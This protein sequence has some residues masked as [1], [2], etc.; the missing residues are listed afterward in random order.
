MEGKELDMDNHEILKTDNVLVRIMEL[1]KDGSTEWHHHTE[2]A[3][4]FVCLKGAVRVETRD[5]EQ[6]TVLL[7]GQHTRV[8]PAQVHRVVNLGESRSDYLL[9][10]GVGVYDFCVEEDL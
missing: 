5:P 3:D 10:Q 1:G 9:I 6:K 2:V 7:P 8:I 4:F